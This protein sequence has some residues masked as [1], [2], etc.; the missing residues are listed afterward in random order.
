MDTI[1]DH[2]MPLQEAARLVRER[3]KAALLRKYGTEW[4]PVIVDR[5]TNEDQDIEEAALWKHFLLASD[6]ADVKVCILKKL[7]GIQDVEISK[8][9]AGTV[10]VCRDLTPSMTSQIVKENVVINDLCMMLLINMV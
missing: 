2:T 7:L 10:L 1:F 9:P 8:L 6:I 3:C 5:M 4:D